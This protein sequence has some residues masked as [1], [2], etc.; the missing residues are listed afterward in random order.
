MRRKKKDDVLPKVLDKNGDDYSQ[1]LDS[2]LNYLAG[3]ASISYSA[4]ESYSEIK[5]FFLRFYKKN[6][7]FLKQLGHAQCTAS[8]GPTC[9]AIIMIK[10]TVAMS[11]ERERGSE[12]EITL[13]SPSYPSL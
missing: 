8:V 7:K 1:D 4:I 10:F 2:G 5:F 6:M 11:S 3:A 12:R 13:S 9:M